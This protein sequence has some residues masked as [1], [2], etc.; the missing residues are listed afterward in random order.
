M[1]EILIIPALASVL[2]FILTK[3]AEKW[4]GKKYDNAE[5]LQTLLVKTNN[6]KDILDH[7]ED[8]KIRRMTAQKESED[9]KA[10]IS[11]FPDLVHKIEALTKSVDHLD[12]NFRN[13]NGNSAMGQMVEA[14]NKMADKF[15]EI[16]H[17]K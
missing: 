6:G 4:F 3:L 14:F 10:I 12:R 16:K 5:A 13:T 17:G 11:A 8:A 15:D 7:L 2:T 9:M 1:P